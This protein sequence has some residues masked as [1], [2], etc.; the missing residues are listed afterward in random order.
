MTVAAR[1]GPRLELTVQYAAPR[2]GLPGRARLEQWAAAA[3]RRGAD[4]TVRFV[5]GREGRSLN[6]AY[7]G[8]DYAT[9]VLTFV[10]ADAP[11]RRL[12]GDLVLCAPVIAREARAQAKRLDAHYAHLVVHGVLHLQGWD[13]AHRHDA[14]AMEQ[15][16]TKILARLGYADPY[17]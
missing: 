2:R 8:R 10:Y 17:A 14:E 9:N 3:L 1:H 16:E 4:V 7:R 6:G 12:S 15:R 5:G 11:R 13:H